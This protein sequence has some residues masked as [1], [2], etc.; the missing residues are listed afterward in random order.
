ML[1]LRLKVSA[2]VALP[3]LLAPVIAVVCKSSE[4][5]ATP[6]PAFVPLTGVNAPAPTLI[7]TAEDGRFVVPTK[8]VN[9]AMALV[10]YAYSATDVC[11]GCRTQ[12]VVT[13]IPALPGLLAFPGVGAFELA[14]DHVSVAPDKETVNEV[15]TVAESATVAVLELVAALAV[16]L[17][18]T[19]KDE[20]AT[21]RSHF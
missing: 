16:V 13:V 9:A 7:S 2:A 17:E 12:L 11:P 3:T 14:V 4:D 10:K 6:K 1:R 5:P 19:A 20:R 15:L 18:R 21:I 8:G